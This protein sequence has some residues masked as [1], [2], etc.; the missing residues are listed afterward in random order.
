MMH[1]TTY[2]P[3][4]LRLI[5]LVSKS[6]PRAALVSHS[7]LSSR[8]R[9][10]SLLCLP[11]LLNLPH[12]HHF[13]LSCLSLIHLSLIPRSSGRICVLRRG[14]SSSSLPK[15]RSKLRLLLCSWR[16]VLYESGHYIIPPREYTNF[17]LVKIV[18]RLP[19]NCKRREK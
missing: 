7:G 3:R 13:S 17:Q 8:R 9:S 11:F 1:S 15:P 14:Y 10:R 2:R 6:N 19:L 16:R 5:A 12:T 18:P 4:I